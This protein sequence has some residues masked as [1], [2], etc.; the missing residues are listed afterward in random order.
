M[1]YHLFAVNN[2]TQQLAAAEAKYLNRFYD[3]CKE[4]F[5]GCHMPSHDHTHHLRVWVYCKQLLR[6][7]VQHGHSF[8][9]D[10]VE[11][12]LAAALFHDIGLSRITDERHG[13]EGAELFKRYVAS[14]PDVRLSLASDIVEAIRVHDLKSPSSLNTAFDLASILTICDNLDSFGYIGAY[15]YAEIY[16][17]R[18]MSRDDVAPRSLINIEKR[19]KSFE[20][21]YAQLPEFYQEQKQRYIQAC[22]VFKDEQTMTEIMNAILQLSMKEQKSI[23]EIAEAYGKKSGL[24]FWEQ[25]QREL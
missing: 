23:T 5:G 19:F 11:A 24:P 2:L 4:I 22:S 20:L 8:S 10:F 1:A 3:A 15:R 13:P 6:Y 14:N 18:G 12:L 17:I 9:N 16:L 7:A 25:L 21:H